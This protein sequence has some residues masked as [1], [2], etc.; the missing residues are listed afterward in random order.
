MVEV[1]LRQ[2]YTSEIDWV[3]RKYQEVNFVK[4]DYNNEFIVIAE[5]DGE[6]AGLGRIVK[7]DEKNVE[8]GG[9][10]VF[11]HFRGLGVA[12]HIVKALCD[13]N[14]FKK[15]VIWCLPFMNLLHFYT[16]FGFKLQADIT[17]PKKIAEKLNWCNTD[18]KYE[19][20][21]LLLAKK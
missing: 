5:I 17:A 14:P 6:N 9:I 18:N 16:K 4:S 10:L 20:E 2:A 11:P 19:K 21:V 8:L 1:K 12:G 3:N 15:S 7:I 13:G